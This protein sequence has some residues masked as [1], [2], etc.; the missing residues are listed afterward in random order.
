[1]IDAIMFVLGKGTSNTM[2]YALGIGSDTSQ[3]APSDALEF[4]AA[5][6]AA[7]R[8]SPCRTMTSPTT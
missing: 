2:K 6:G 1:M 4:S 8:V 7:V 5:S 3:G